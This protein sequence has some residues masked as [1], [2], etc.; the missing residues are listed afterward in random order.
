MS[1]VVMLLNLQCL[2]G[3]FDNLWHHELQADLRHQPTARL[4]L[5]LHTARELLY[6]VVFLGVAWWS[7]QG[8]WAVVLAAILLAEL[9]ITLWD[10]VEEDRSRKLPAAERVLHSLIAL[11]YGAVLALWAPELLRWAAAPTG[12]AAADYGLWSWLLTVFGIGVLGWGLMDL[13]AVLRLRAPQWQRQPLTVG[14]KAAPQTIVITGAT[15][16]IGSALLRRLV[17]RGDRVIVLSRRVAKARNR[18]GPAVRVVGS[19]HDIAADERIDAIVN[20]AGEPLVGGLWTLQRKQRFIDSRVQTTRAVGSLIARLRHQPAVLISASAIGWYGERGDER[21]TENSATGT[22]FLAT[23]CQQW[24][25]A[26]LDAAG[27][28]V[29][30]CS[31]RIGLVLAAHGGV[32]QPLALATRFGGGLVMGHGAQWQ[33]WIHLEDLLRLIEHALADPTLQG[34]VNAVAPQP[35]T[36]RE[37]MQ[38]LARTLHRPLWLV[39]PAWLLRALAGEMSSLFLVSQRVGP[40]RAVDAGFRFRWPYL[41]QALAA[42]YTAPASKSHRGLT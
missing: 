5:A 40:Q 11:N 42:L 28:A 30:L 41:D 27:D 23:L 34:P 25:A 8:V 20:L 12:F 18:F 38:Q 19:L 14:V 15:G 17:V 26:A 22:G 37:F 13:H 36:Q 6:A 4:E 2:M 9:A 3:A 35:V 16:F 29:R 21:L 39:M 10:F 24:E 32:L 7:W 31:L 33:S 1:A